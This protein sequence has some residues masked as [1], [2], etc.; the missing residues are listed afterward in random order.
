MIHPAPDHGALDLERERHA[1]AAKWQ[2]WYEDA[3][4]FSDVLGVGARLR[5]GTSDFGRWT[6][7]PVRE[8][9]RRC[10]DVDFEPLLDSAPPALAHRLGVVAAITGHY[11]YS[12]PLLRAAAHAIPH[13]SDARRAAVQNWRLAA[14]AAHAWAAALEAVQMLARE[15]PYEV[16]FPVAYYE[17]L[18]MLGVGGFAEAYLCRDLAAGTLVV[19]KALARKAVDQWPRDVF[20]EV[21]LLRSL[22]HPGVPRVREAGYVDPDL[23]HGPFCVTEY[24]DGMSLQQ[25][26][27]QC[28]AISWPNLRC[29]LLSVLDILETVHQAGI[30]H[31]DVKPGNIL[32][33]CDSHG[34]QTQL[35][36]F[37]I[38]VNL[39]QPISETRDGELRPGTIGFA[40]PEQLGCP[41]AT[42]ITSAVDVYA[43]GQTAIYALTRH[44]P[45]K[46]SGERLI[47]GDSPL[48]EVLLSCVHHDPRHRPRVEQLRRF[49]QQ[50]EIE[51]NQVQ[52]EHQTTRLPP[53]INGD[54]HAW[55]SEPLTGYG[56]VGGE[57]ADSA[58]PDGW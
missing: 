12:W 35:I 32:L 29:I 17:P 40:A 1:V 19:V 6:D 5:L 24:F 43:L 28:G 37:G 33:R 14:L 16:P 2:P 56:T 54:V 8:R 34:W 3:I 50:V 44:L 4:A 49:L 7:V 41:F 10:L 27:A 47:P 36:D 51:H 55:H 15:A 52:Q 31:C 25:Y 18:R 9:V 45:G 13:H 42:P 38:G 48:H 11:R 22:S 30:A 58:T 46:W 23:Q 26:L 20:H 57:A 21:Q 39:S 53:P